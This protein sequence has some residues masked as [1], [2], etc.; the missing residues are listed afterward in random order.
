MTFL[1]PTLTFVILAGFIFN[2]AIPILRYKT[3][4]QSAYVLA[5]VTLISGLSIYFISYVAISISSTLCAS[6]GFFCKILRHEIIPGSEYF[7]LAMS[8][9]AHDKPDSS[10]KV[11]NSSVSAV[12]IS[13]TV[14]FLFVIAGVLLPQRFVQLIRRITISKEVIK[15][16]GVKGELINSCLRAGSPILITLNNRKVYAGFVL[17]LPYMNEREDWYIKLLPLRSG[18][19]DEKI[20]NLSM[21]HNYEE[22]WSNLDEVI[23]DK[24]EPQDKYDRLRNAG[25]VINWNDIA[26][27]SEWIPEIYNSFNSKRELSD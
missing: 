11:I 24:I 16:M 20:L 7:Y 21:T 13:L 1:L 4:N 15:L 3:K 8:S 10:L 2:Q 5:L 25:I 12:L 26:I 19:R 14:Y 22:I 18:Y 9:I 6:P 23:P 27:A 17:E